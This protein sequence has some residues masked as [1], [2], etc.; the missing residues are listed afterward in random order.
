VLRDFSRIKFGTETGDANQIDA[1]VAKLWK[2]QGY[3]ALIPLIGAVK[4]FVK[5]DDLEIC[6]ASRKFGLTAGFTVGTFF[7]FT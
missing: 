5:K 4:G 7:P 1:A 6:E 3:Q 2:H